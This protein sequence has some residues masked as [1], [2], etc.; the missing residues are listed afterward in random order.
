M[1][2]LDI[3]GR[4]FCMRGSQPL[5]GRMIRVDNQMIKRYDPQFEYIKKWIPAFKDLTIKE[6][7]AKMKE[8]EPM[9]QWRD[10]YIKYTKLFERL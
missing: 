1:G 4:R 6:C 2:D 9:Y 3:A 10:R 7:K 5:T 8:I